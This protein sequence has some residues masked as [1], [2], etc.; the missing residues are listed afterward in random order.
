[1]GNG[2][3]RVELIMPRPHAGQL[4]VMRDQTRFR[5]VACGRRWGKSVGALCEA[6]A[7][8]TRPGARVWYIAP[9]YP[10]VDHHWRTYRSMLPPAAPCQFNQVARRVTFANGAEVQFQNA[11][12]PDRLRGAGLDFVI[13]D[14]AAFI[15][16]GG[17]LL[18]EVL[19][20][21]L[22]DRKGRLLAISTP[23]GHNHFASWYQRGLGADE[24]WR[25]WQYP[26]DTNPHID[27][28]EI[29]AARQAMPDRV[30]R[31]EFLAE[32]IGDGAVLRG[33]RE[34]VVDPAP[35]AR[36]GAR[37]VIGV[38]WG[39]ADDFTVAVALDADTGEVV[40]VDR[41]NQIS[42]RLQRGRV[43]AMAERLNPTLI[44]VETNSIGEPQLEELTDDGLPALGF[45]TTAQS[46]QKL[47]DGLAL[48]FEQSRLRI[49]DMPELIHECQA[50]TMTRTPSGR[51][52]YSAPA[53]QHDDCVMALALAWQACQE[54]TRL[55]EWW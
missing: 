44:L 22:A 34:A 2:T 33:V 15:A 9:T 19:R 37:I 11:S 27:G 3:R 8:C 41:F 23:C 30:F 45:Q 35:V 40:E 6:T 24:G 7:A 26:T 50:Y 48:A 32:F 52:Q 53:G 18:D 4:A 12:D 17:R 28:D 39:K 21:A 10:M 54:P 13:L 51:Y 16:D 55:L 38:D 1:M 31:Q 47:I 25:S 29:D 20:P 14:E 36:Q 43:A 42:W 46:K 5:V 49:P